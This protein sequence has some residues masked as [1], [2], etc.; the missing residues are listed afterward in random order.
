MLNASVDMLYHLGHKQY[1]EA[2]SDAIRKT[3]CEDRIHTPG[4]SIWSIVVFAD[5]ENRQ[6]SHL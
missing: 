6:I 2:I 4:K 5:I 3:I 1:A